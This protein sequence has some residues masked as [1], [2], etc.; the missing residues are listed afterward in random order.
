MGRGDRPFVT[1]AEVWSIH[2]SVWVGL[3]WVRSDADV[4]FRWWVSQA[5]SFTLWVGRVGSG[6][7]DP[8]LT[9]CHEIGRC[10]PTIGA[11]RIEQTEGDRS[12]K[13]RGRLVA[14]LF[15]S[16]RCHF[17]SSSF[18]A[19]HTPTTTLEAWAALAAA[20]ALA[21]ARALLHV[22]DPASKDY[23]ALLTFLRSTDT[24][25]FLVSRTRTNFSDRA[26]CAAGPQSGTICK[27]TS[28]SRTCHTVVSRT[29]AESIFIWSVG[30]S[31]PLTEERQTTFSAKTLPL[32]VYEIP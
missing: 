8:C 22:V 3:N 29:V 5:G 15:V 32:L 18:G 4:Q 13:R 24:H 14:D 10:Q 19:R 2:G 30:S 12:S 7:L 9:V 6:N 31:Y 23:A 16:Y 21:T 17:S 27:R 25:A 20:V 28:D 26:F 1:S 11:Q